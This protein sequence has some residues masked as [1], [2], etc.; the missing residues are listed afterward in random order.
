MIILFFRLMRSSST[1][2][3]SSA[4]WS[5][6]LCLSASWSQAIWRTRWGRYKCQYRKWSLLYCCVPITSCKSWARLWSGK[7]PSSA[8]C[9]VPFAHW[10]KM[11]DRAVM[12][13]LLFLLLSLINSVN[14][15]FVLQR[16]HA[17]HTCTCTSLTQQRIN[18][19]PTHRAYQHS[20]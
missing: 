16:T 11:A 5:D 15:V 12:Q 20:T 2:L 14:R 10:T 8:V 3:S 6:S 17:L 19:K 7:N 18:L 1:C 9:S 13:R 4:V